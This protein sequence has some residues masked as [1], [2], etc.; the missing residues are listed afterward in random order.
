MLHDELAERRR[1]ILGGVE[2]RG[3]LRPAVAVGQVGRVVAEHEQRPAGRNRVGGRPHRPEHR[4]SVELEVE[5]GNESN[6]RASGR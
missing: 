5:D 1:E 6:A 2:D 3:I 4:L